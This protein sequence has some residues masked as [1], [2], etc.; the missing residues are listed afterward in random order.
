MLL[1]SL[2]IVFAL[3]TAQTLAWISSYYLALIRA[4]LIA[5]DLG[6]SSI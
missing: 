2:L 5:R 6:I 1:R 3:G 4:D